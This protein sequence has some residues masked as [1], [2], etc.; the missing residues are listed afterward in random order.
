MKQ[1]NSINNDVV[2]F[3]PVIKSEILPEY[4]KEEFVRKAWIELAIEDVPIEV[5]NEDFT[6]PTENEHQVLIDSISVNVSYQVSVGY[7]REEPYIAYEDYWEDEP[8]LATES[9]YDYDTKSTRTRQVTKYKKVKKQRQ[10]TKYKKVTDWSPLNGTHSAD[11][12]AV[13]ENIPGQY[14]DESAFVESFRGAN[15]SSIISASPELIETMVVNEMANDKAQSEHRY[16]IDRSVKHS[17]PGDHYRDLDWRVVDTTSSSTKLYKTPEYEATICFNGK[18]YKKRA[19]PFGPM[20]I[21]GDKIKNEISLEAVT[22]KMKTDLNNKITNRKNKI[23]ENVSKATNMISLITILL[24]LSSILISLFVRSIAV[25]LIVFAVS[26]V[27]F[28]FNTLKVKSETNLEKTRANNEIKA[29]TDKVESE[30]SNYSKDYKI[31]QREALNIKLK[32]LGFE[33]VSS[34][35]M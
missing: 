33:P 7:D 11:S 29:E 35:E 12:V 13:V 2:E 25:V 21:N 27:A 15:D 17:L 30:I 34:E 32:S 5:F 31:K 6:N 20:S 18:T 19:F 8:Y 16:T 1:S 3:D 26:V 23:E 14:L 28:I 9:Y 10:V 22:S 24:L 4:S